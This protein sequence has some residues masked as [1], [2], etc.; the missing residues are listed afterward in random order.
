MTDQ[1]VPSV[2]LVPANEWG[3][4]CGCTPDGPAV[5]IADN[6]VITGSPGAIT[7]KQAGNSLWALVLNDGTPAADFR[8]D[9][10]DDTGALLDS[11]MGIVRATGVVSFNDPVMLDG[12]PVQPLEAATKAYVDA[13][14]GIPDAPND[15]HYYARFGNAWATVPI[16]SDAPSDG[17]LYARWDNSWQALPPTPDLSVLMPKSGG[18][19]TGPVTFPSNNSVVIDGAINTQHAILGRVAGLMRWQLQMPDM[20]AEGVGN[21][22]A[23]FSLSAFSTTGATLG[24]WLTIARADGATSFNGASVYVAGGLSINGV[25]LVSN[26]GNLYVPGGSPGQ[27][28]Q[29]NGAGLLSWGGAGSAGVPE[30][31]NDGNAYLRA[32]SGWV[33]GGAIT[34]TM[35]FLPGSLLN[36]NTAVLKIA[37]GASGSALTTDGSGN[38]SWQ[39][40]PAA[41]TT[42]PLANGT[43]AIGTSTTYARADH[44]HPSDAYPHDNRIINGDMRID[45]RN[46]GAL[47]T[48]SG[49]TIDR[50]QVGGNP[51]G[52][53]SAQRGGPPGLL[54]VAGFPYFLTATSLS[55]Y[56]A[57]P[58]D[59][60]SLYQAIE[61]D[62]VSDF[63]FGTVN[64][65]PVTLSF[66]VNSGL[67]TGTF[68]GRLAASGGARSFPFTFDI[69]ATN[70]WIKV[71]I[72]IPGDTGG[73]WLM[74]GNGVGIYVQFDLGCGANS[75]GPA[76]AWSSS[77]FIGV[78]GAI[79]IVNTINATFNITGV[80]LEIGNVATP[81][82]RQ[83]LAK[84]L[85]DCQRYYQLVS[86]AARIP[87]SAATQF[88]ESTLNW[89]T[90]RAAPTAAVVTA[91]SNG[92]LAAT[93]PILNSITPQGSRFSIGSAA[94]GDCFALAYVYGLSAE[95]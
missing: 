5:A 39:P 85:A 29:T 46:N 22:G 56:I 10:F 67:M 81:F 93:F 15:G 57:A 84:S 90:M 73:P 30:A 70:T 34:G 53:L 83:S 13:K 68:S 82:N 88:G 33:S 23:N 55:A 37:G 66:W 35:A 59:V 31:P 51:A 36:L 65:Q 14:G 45:Q 1:W 48:A 87:A 91:G 9:R 21:A 2:P 38:V 18:T 42:T 74:N 95:L 12:D 43:A 71:V 58:T 78:T 75:R 62:A 92:N 19:F 8:I 27:F 80:K 94:A 17:Q 89:Q 16:Q 41:S 76:G 6:I 28:L 63:R 86:A 61:S 69:S 60:F 79:S 50:W 32:S 47:V 25:L 44:V 64:A 20:T 3:S 54:A 26:V 49:Y 7:S 52:K 72:T 77:N 40:T 11:P 24:A 4:T